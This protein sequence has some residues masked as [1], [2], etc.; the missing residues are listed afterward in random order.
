MRG[1]NVENGPELAGF[2]PLPRAAWT[3]EARAVFAFWGEPGAYDNGSNSNMVMT[4]AHH[5]A[6]AIAY[7]TFGK[8][9]MIASTLPVRDRELIVLRV[10]WLLRSAYEWHYHVGYALNLGMSL[11]EIAAIGAG[12]AAGNWNERDAA[13][14]RAVEELHR[15]SRLSDE[16]RRSLSR[17]FDEQQHIDMVFTIGNYVMLSWAISALDIELEDGI[18]PIGFD[19]RTRSG[20]L[21]V[22]RY[23]PGEA[24]DWTSNR[25]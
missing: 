3:E 21:P 15:Q 16:C 4:L 23:K 24:E 18:D 9:L 2:A 19:L 11:D 10:A 25:G 22:A 14:L 12:S 5:P 13:V 17:H 6:L 1:G 8:H 20:A 7:Y